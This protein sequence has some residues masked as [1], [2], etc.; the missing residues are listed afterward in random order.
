MNHNARI[1]SCRSYILRAVYVVV[2][3]LIIIIRRRYARRNEK[4]L[5]D[6]SVVF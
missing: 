4:Y 1:M 6:A 5:E 2:L 3:K